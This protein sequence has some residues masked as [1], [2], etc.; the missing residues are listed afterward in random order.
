MK[1]DWTFKRIS[2]IATVNP[3][4]SIKKGQLAKKVAMDQLQ[5]F[6]RDIPRFELEAFS[7]MA[8]PSWPELLRALKTEKLQK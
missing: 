2:D 3:R 7:E 4:E 5:S 8:I 6:T 1:S